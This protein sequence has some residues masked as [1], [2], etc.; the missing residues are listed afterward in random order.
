M[1]ETPQRKN[2]RL[3][4]FDYYSNAVYFVTV[5]A[6]DRQNLFGDIVGG[7]AY[8]APPYV[9][10]NKTGKIA[11]KYIKRIE[12]SYDNAFVDKYAVMPNHIHMILALRS[13]TMRACPLRIYRCLRLYAR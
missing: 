9:S 2:N 12:L 11:D 8:I 5:C 4:G 1:T 7:D 6:R 10:L 3:A 13:G